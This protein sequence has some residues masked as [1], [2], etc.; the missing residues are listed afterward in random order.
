VDDAIVVVSAINQYKR[1][2]KFTTREAALLVLR[3]FQVVLIATTLT[4]VWIFSAMLFMTGIIGKF[5]FS[6]P[7]VITVT[8]L[9]SLLVALFINPALSVMLDSL[10][11]KKLME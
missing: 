2:G 1:T 4:V 11:G 9:A 10:D 8:L 5:I 7:F 3:D 6:I